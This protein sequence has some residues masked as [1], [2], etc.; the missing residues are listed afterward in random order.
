MT[1][2]TNIFF[3]S[4]SLMS[5]P[6]SLYA[7]SGHLSGSASGSQGDPQKHDRDRAHD[8]LEIVS[9]VIKVVLMRCDTP[10]ETSTI[11]NIERCDPFMEMKGLW[12]QKC[13]V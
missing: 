3:V 1:F 9:D 6:T 2:S 5:R 8:S 10:E 7:R 12:I 11:V 13:R 4:C